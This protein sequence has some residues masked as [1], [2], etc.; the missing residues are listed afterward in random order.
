MEKN[1]NFLL[2]DKHVD[3]FIEGLNEFIL[4]FVQFIFN[5]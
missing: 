2:F 1:E 3:C 4:V 5:K